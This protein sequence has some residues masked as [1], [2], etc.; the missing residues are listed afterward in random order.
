MDITE[1]LRRQM[2]A[3]GVPEKALEQAAQKWDTE[4]L[5]AEFDV[6]GFAAPFVIVVRK[7]DKQRGLLMFTHW[8]RWYFDFHPVGEPQV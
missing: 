6:M 7:A 3:D 2:I 5:K 4:Q 1:D 8:P